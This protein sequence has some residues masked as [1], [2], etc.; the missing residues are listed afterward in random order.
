MTYFKTEFGKNLKLIRK[1][2][3][4]TQEKLARMI[5]LNQRQLTRIEN[6]I[7]FVSSEVIEKLVIALNIELKDLFDF[8]IK[9]NTEDKKEKEQDFLYNKTIN[10]IFNKIKKHAKNEKQLKY[11]E[12]AIDSLSNK[13][14]RKKLQTLINGIEAFE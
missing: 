10:N 1:S 9:D 5:N 14:A 3:G 13:R 12:L 2:K 7:S 11:I 4:L 8:E 6:G